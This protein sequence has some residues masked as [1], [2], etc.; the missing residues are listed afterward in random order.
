M[1][2]YLII[3]SNKV[4]NKWD[5]INDISIILYRNKQITSGSF[6]QCLRFVSNSIVLDC[7]E[8]RTIRNFET[9]LFKS[10]IIFY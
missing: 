4:P 7:F 3:G 9:S 6:W 10:K 1:R 5:E 8:E 2:A